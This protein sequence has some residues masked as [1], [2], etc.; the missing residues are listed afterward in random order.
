M[1]VVNTVAAPV[2]SNASGNDRPLPVMSWR[3]RSRPRNPAWPFVRMEYLGLFLDR[4]QSPDPADPE[5]DLLTQ[6]V[7]GAPAVKAVGHAAGVVGVF[8]DVGVEH[9]QLD[10]THVGDPQLGDKCLPGEVDG[11]PRPVYQRQGHGVRVHDRVALF[12]PTVGVQALAEI[13]LPVEQSD[14]DHR[15]PEAAGRL[16]VV[17]SEDPETSRVLRVGPRLSRTRGKSRPP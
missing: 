11:D 16:E 13:A 6:A 3:I 1:W 4:V 12:L 7:L 15:H 9:V 10:A 14:P 8:L 2:T 17:T 5:E